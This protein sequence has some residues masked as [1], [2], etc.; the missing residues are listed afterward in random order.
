M[1]K[2]H[3]FILSLIIS[4]TFISVPSK[5]QY[6]KNFENGIT[7]Y[8]W[9]AA[10]LRWGKSRVQAQSSTG[11]FGYDIESADLNDDGTTDVVFSAPANQGSTCDQTVYGTTNPI[12]YGRIYISYNNGNDI[13]DPTYF[14]STPPPF[15][16]TSDTL[17][18]YF[19][20]KLFE[21][22]SDDTNQFP[23]LF[24]HKIWGVDNGD[25]FG[26][27]VT[28]GNFD[29]DNL[30]DILV[31]AP[32][33]SFGDGGAYLV[34]GSTLANL[35]GYDHYISNIYDIH[36]E[37]FTST[38][39]T[40]TR[41][42]AS[43]SHADV[44]N[45]GLD[46]IAIGS[47]NWEDGVGYLNIILGSTIQQILTGNGATP[48]VSA[49]IDIDTINSSDWAFYP[50]PTNNDLFGYKV[51]GLGDI[52]N[53][54]YEDLGIGSPY[55]SHNGNSSSGSVYII[56]GGTDLQNPGDPAS[57]ILDP[58]VHITYRY[59]G[60]HQSANLGSS[61]SSAGDVNGDGY[62]DIIM[63]A[64]D[65]WWTNASLNDWYSG[66]AYIVLGNSLTPGNQSANYASYK[67][68]PLFTT[69][70][71]NSDMGMFVA[72]GG[73]IDG[74]G[75]DDIAISEYH[76]AP[77]C[78]I[79]GPL[80]LSSTSA[81]YNVNYGRVV[82]HRGADL[83][84]PPASGNIAVQIWNS[85]A[86]F[87]M[88]GYAGDPWMPDA[89]M[90]EV[91]KFIGDLNQD[92][93]DELMISGYDGFSNYGTDSNI[94][95]LDHGTVYT[96]YGNSPQAIYCY[97]DIDGDGYGGGFPIIENSGSCSGSMTTTIWDCNESDPAINMGVTEICG[98]GIDQDCNGADLACVPEDND[99][100][101][102]TNLDG[103]CDDNNAN[104]YPGNT[105]ICDN[106]DNNC[107][108]QVDEGFDA[109]SDGVT[110]CD[111]DCD[112]SDAS[113]NPLA[114]ESCNS[115]DDNCNGQVDEGFDGDGDGVTTCAGDCDDNDPLRFPG[116]IEVCN[117]GIDN[118]CNGQVDEADADLDGDGVPGCAGDC[119]DNDDD[120]FP[121]NIES[122]DGIDNNCNGQI[123]EGLDIDT[124]GDG[125][126]VCE[127]DCNENHSGIYPGAPEICDHMDNDCDGITD[128]SS[129]VDGDGWTVCDGDCD[130]SD[131]NINPGMPEDMNDGIDNNCDG[132]VDKVWQ[133]EP[134]PPAIRDFLIQWFTEW[135]EAHGISKP[136]DDDKPPHDGDEGHPPSP[137]P[138]SNP[139]KDEP[140]MIDYIDVRSVESMI[141]CTELKGDENQ[142]GFR[143]LC[144]KLDEKDPSSFIKD[145]I[146]YT[147]ESEKDKEKEEDPKK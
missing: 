132:L 138:P 57:L 91:P 71:N 76:K 75:L 85:D 83:P 118:N 89:D 87:D 144:A 32:C 133:L 33:S 127:G 102:V 62:Q 66:Q 14:L 59:D 100:D 108:G 105:E 56:S 79:W 137:P 136:G 77:F 134:V 121:G 80:C 11:M 22:Y 126:T 117:D 110:S 107:D 10:S 67:F 25:Q 29:G 122:C 55:A 93:Y 113:I 115:L 19:G 98:D 30:P 51:E 49:Q 97:E 45:D 104:V 128:E 2:K 146:K 3:L 70:Y 141:K 48:G 38:T 109:D 23:N 63:G 116:N 35:T 95:L 41:T 130:D 1:S 72:G 82:I 99:G 142:D 52:N 60:R 103:D 40:P 143:S 4:L 18:Y 119:D 31:G 84:A 69:T 53:D 88:I 7:G 15:V 44:N 34:L 86:A 140:A 21:S 47:P 24:G 81:V 6:I 135:L 92:G 17:S 73:D 94:S 125:Y 114:T 68:K 20:W 120:I 42:G 96:V 39:G 90:A 58:Y 101:G 36:F 28:I 106:I 65:Q 13:Y 50:N 61:I 131:P 8:S 74:D 9:T 123:D 54:G 147:I 26:H 145:C 139:C 46:D 64:P 111:G 112:D 12:S 27:D 16:P 124:D 37:G 78:W 129:D 43:L 5:A